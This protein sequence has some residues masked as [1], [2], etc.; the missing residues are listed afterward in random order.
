MLTTPYATH[1]THEPNIEP[2]REKTNN[3]G[4]PLRDGGVQSIFLRGESDPPKKMHRNQS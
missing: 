2:M 1:S 4:L 3:H